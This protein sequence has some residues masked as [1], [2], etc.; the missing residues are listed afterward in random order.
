MAQIDDL[1]ILQPSAERVEDS[2]ESEVSAETATSMTDWAEKMGLKP[3]VQMA[4]DLR[5]IFHP[6][7]KT[8]SLMQIVH[9]IEY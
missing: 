1:H 6:T 4:Q 3:T 2:V 5:Y 7:C 9:H 8:L